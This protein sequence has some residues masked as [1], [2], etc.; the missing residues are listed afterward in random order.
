V[1]RLEDIAKTAVAPALWGTTYIVTTQLLPPD[2]PLLAATL[3]ALP[4][5]ILILAVYRRWPPRG[6]R[7]KVA[8]LAICNIGI[9]FPLLF[10]A[11]YRLPGGVAATV[12]SIQPIFVA[13]LAWPVLREPPGVLSIAAGI[14]GAGGVALIAWQGGPIASALGIVAAVAAALSVA[15]GIVLQKRWALPASPT[16]MSGWQLGLGGLILLPLA[17]GFEGVPSTV[18]A[19]NI[20]G[21]IY[22]SAI[23]TGFAYTLWFRGITRLGPSPVAFL[24]LLSPIV[25]I[26]LGYFFLSQPLDMRQ[27]V[28]VALVL[29]AVI[30][31]QNRR[32]TVDPSNPVGKWSAASGSESFA[33]RSN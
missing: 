14:I 21:L 30:L 8:V 24:L 31:G 17:L 15:V 10:V 13:F 32:K 28:G 18:S 6:G 22:L 29:A 20:I 7:L 25:A 1:S 19:N 2:R 23:A 4:I 16:L 3:R 12:M 5:G 33:R 26:V 27:G 11:A 9:F